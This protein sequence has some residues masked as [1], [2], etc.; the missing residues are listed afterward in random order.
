MRE[1]LV[2]LA[3]PREK[4]APVTE[5]RST[6]ITAAL[7]ALKGA[8][9][10][11]AYCA[12]LPPG[13]REKM[14]ALLT[15]IR[16][17]IEYGD[18]HY[19]TGETLDLAPREILA[20]GNAVERNAEKTIFAFVLRTAREAGTTPATVIASTPRMWARCFKGGC[21]AAY[22]VGPKDV[23]FESIGVPMARYRYFRTGYRAV[24]TS[25]LAPF[26]TKVICK[27]LPQLTT[28]SAFAVS[29]AWA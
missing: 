14:L 5:V 12:K 15:G 9:L 17:P 13:W 22:K 8:N 16:L 23:V 19:R 27:E 10:L 11:D 21:V 25:L 7:G 28:D 1:E 26:C 24:V 3:V 20:L 6:L 18:V 29:I 2:P 4:V